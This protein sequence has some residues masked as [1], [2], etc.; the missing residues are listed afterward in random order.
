MENRQLPNPMALGAL[1]A[2][3]SAELTSSWVSS[4]HAD[5]ETALVAAGAGAL[6]VAEDPDDAADMLGAHPVSTVQV[7]MLAAR[8]DRRVTSL[9]SVPSLSPTQGSCHS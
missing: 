1:T 5:A 4:L 3:P 7:I 6:N 2:T 8:H 9:G